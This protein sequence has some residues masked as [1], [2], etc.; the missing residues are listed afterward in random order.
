MNEPTKFGAYHKI[1]SI[2]KRD[3]EAPG[4]PFIMD[5]FSVPE[6]EYLQYNEWEF[7]EKVDGTNIR[8]LW[9]WEIEELR[10]GGRTDKSQIP[11]DLV[12]ALHRAFDVDK[13]KEKFPGV[14]VIFYGEGYG[15][16]I[17]KGSGHDGPESFVLF[18][19]R[20]GNWWLQREDVDGVGEA[21]GLDVVPVIGRGTLI[22]GITKVIS[23]LKSTYGDFEAEGLI[24]RPVMELKSRNGSRIITKIKG[25]DFK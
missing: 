4:K 6:F 23:V 15:G 14:D 12:S 1:N 5:S 2:F 18:D 21:L 17:Q 16:K 24:A 20:I 7:T 8:V 19:V 3:M 22:S 10:F 11:A 13:I 25:C 9:E